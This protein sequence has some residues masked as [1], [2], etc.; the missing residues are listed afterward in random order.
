MKEIYDLARAG[1]TERARALDAELQ[2]VYRT[3]FI[4]PPPS[5][6]KAALRLLGI[7]T[8]GVRLPIVELDEAELTDV[9][10]MV[11]ALRPRVAAARD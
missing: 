10:R 11:E 8:G 4:A 9:R 7:E 2:D 5:T 1:E 3:I 6:L